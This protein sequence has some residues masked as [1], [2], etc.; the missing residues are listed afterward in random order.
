M[1]GS[2]RALGKTDTH[3]ES[4]YHA[5]VFL[6]AYL[7]DGEIGPVATPFKLRQAVPYE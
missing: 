4:G 6:A 2:F 5:Q 3:R 7:Q 1:P